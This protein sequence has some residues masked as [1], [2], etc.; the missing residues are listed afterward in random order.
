MGAEAQRPD[1]VPAHHISVLQ[2]YSC[3]LRHPGSQCDIQLLGKGILEPMGRLERGAGLLRDELRLQGARV[4]RL[5]CLCGRHRGH[6]RRRQLPALRLGHRRPAPALGQHPPRPGAVRAA[7][8]PDRPVEDH[9][10]REEPPDLPVGLLHPH[11]P[12]C[13]NLHC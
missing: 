2:C 9:Q 6:Q 10:E 12:V 4:L 13:R 1:L 7:H 3:A 5:V 11:G 8:V